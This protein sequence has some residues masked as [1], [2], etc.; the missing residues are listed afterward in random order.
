MPISLVAGSLLSLQFFA[1]QGSMP[2]SSADE[3][4]AELVMFAAGGVLSALLATGLA[5][6]GFRLRAER[7]HSDSPGRMATA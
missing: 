2:L 5:V 1:M 6:L 4:A 7:A 3:R